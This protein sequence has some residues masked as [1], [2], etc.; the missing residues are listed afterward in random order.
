MVKQLWYHENQSELGEALVAVVGAFKIRD[1]V[2]PVAQDIRKQ[3]AIQTQLQHA[4]SWDGYL[5]LLVRSA[6]DL[7]ILVMRSGIVGANTRRKLSIEEFRGFAVSDPLAPLVFINGGDPLVAQI[8]TFAHE[9]AHLWVGES[10]IS[11]VDPTQAPASQRNEVER[12]CDS[13]AAEVLVPASEFMERWQGTNELQFQNLARHFRV[14]II[15]VI[16]RAYELGRINSTQFVKFVAQE[17]QRQADRAAI[18]EEESSGGNFYNTLPV[19]NSAKLTNAVLESLQQGRTSPLEAARLLG[20]RAATL[21]TLLEGRRSR[22][23]G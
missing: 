16:R 3:L 23:E 13:V 19:R 6:E 22:L 2:Q 15:V 12:F 5:R 8:F 4:G 21:T 14:S 10:A 9:I 11:N 18:P 7:G 1:G 17:K 20:I